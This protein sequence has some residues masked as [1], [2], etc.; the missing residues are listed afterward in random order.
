MKSRESKTIRYGFFT[1]AN[2]TTKDKGMKLITRVG[3]L[4]QE[5]SR[6]RRKGR[7]IGFVPT[8]GGLHEGHVSLLKRA[9]RDNDV[10][11]LSIFVNPLQFGPREDFHSYP[12]DL[13][14]DMLRIQ[15][16]AHIVFAPKAEHFYPSDFCTF[17]EVRGLSER[18]C[19]RSRPGHFTGVATVVSKLLNSVGPDT[20]Y[21]GQ[22]DA[23]QAV[24]IQKM[25]R[26]L[27]MPVHIKVLPIMREKDGLAMS[28]RN[29]YLSPRERQE[30]LVLYQSL[31]SARRLVQSGVRDVH[32]I[33]DVLGGFIA[34]TPAARI[35]YLAIV[36]PE[37]LEPLKK[38]KREGLLLLAVFIGKTRLIDN[39][40]LKVRR[41]RTS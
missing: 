38:I 37:T 39:A 33:L 16:L 35:D 31:Q 5:L 28:S 8:M 32:K 29:A 13:K 41:T 6:Q 10:V 12:R 11:V 4:R 7:T 22:K 24:I 34:H 9:A 25:V 2:I 26:D 15:G 23:Q 36:E 18:L 27:N 1:G 19:G 14:K 17:V 21:F 3:D 30:A 20:A 40:I